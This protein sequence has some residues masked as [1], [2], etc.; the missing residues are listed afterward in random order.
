MTLGTCGACVAFVV[1]RLYANAT[2]KGLA[3]TS[4]ASQVQRVG[5]TP[6]ESS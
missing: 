2:A 5:L 1:L 4:P 3:A 6:E